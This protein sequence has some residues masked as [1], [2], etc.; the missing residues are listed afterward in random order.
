MRINYTRGISMGRI[1][2]VGL[3]L[4]HDVLWNHCRDRRV[5]VIRKV[6]GAPRRPQRGIRARSGTSSK[7]VAYRLATARQP[8]AGSDLEPAHLETAEGVPCD[9]TSRPT[10]S[11]PNEES[12]DFDGHKLTSARIRTR[13]SPMQTHETSPVSG[14]SFVGMTYGACHGP[15]NLPAGVLGVSTPLG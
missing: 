14:A 4:P 1:T 11:R 9:L 6:T 8:P 13:R 7:G 15:S 3:A 2:D 5:Q 12:W 10:T